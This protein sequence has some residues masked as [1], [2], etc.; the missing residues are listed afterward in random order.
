[1]IKFSASLCPDSTQLTNKR[2]DGS[3]WW[4]LEAISSFTKMSGFEGSTN[5]DAVRMVENSTRLVGGVVNGEASVVK[6]TFVKPC[7]R[8]QG[9]MTPGAK[10]QFHF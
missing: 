4:K 2:E 1:M 7:I 5:F 3:T 10:S 6:N 8:F 9:E